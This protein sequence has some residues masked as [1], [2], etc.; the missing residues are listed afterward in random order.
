MSELF[1]RS[2]EKSN[3]RESRQGNPNLKELCGK[4]KSKLIKDLKSQLPINFKDDATS[5][6]DILCNTY[7]SDDEIQAQINPGDNVSIALN[8]EVITSTDTQLSVI[9]YSET[10]INEGTTGQQL[11]NKSYSH[12]IIRLGVSRKSS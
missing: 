10:I 5:V 1:R 2:G 7:S 6:I 12:N 3:P 9:L 4:Q 8:V 11:I